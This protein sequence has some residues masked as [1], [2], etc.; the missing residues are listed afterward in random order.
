MKHLIKRRIITITAILIALFLGACTKG[1]LE[2]YDADGQLKTAC[3]TVYTWQPS[4]DKYAVEYVLA[5]CARK[6]QEQGLTVKD[7]R[8]L[9]IDLS[10]PVSPEGQP[11]T[12]DLAREHH[13][14]GLITDKQYG[15]IL[16][17]IDL[18]YPVIEG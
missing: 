7:Q 18:G 8:L 15:Y 9:D 17:Y 6:A 2:Y 5:H 1:K 12:F 13:Q 11:W 14:K 4:V 10:V 16:A 3:E